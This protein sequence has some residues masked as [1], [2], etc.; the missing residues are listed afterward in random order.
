MTHRLETPPLAAALRR[1]AVRVAAVLLV[2]VLVTW[3]MDRVMPEDAVAVLKCDG[4]RLGLLLATLAIY[5]LFIAIPFV[6]GIEIGASLLLFGGATVAPYVYIAT[7]VGLMLAFL[8]GRLVSYDWLRQV[9]ADVRMMR[10]CQL[11]DDMKPLSRERRLT[12][13]RQRLPG[14]AEPIAIRGRYVLLA[15]LLVLPGNAVIGG[16]GGICLLAGLTRLYST[17]VTLLTIGIAVL[18]IPLMVWL[19]NVDVAAFF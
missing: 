12:L 13:L 19:F 8:V 16:G 9:F 17:P 10:M 5:A 2:I 18:P 14:W 3:A 1:I 4:M 6:P 15:L 7:V 11:L